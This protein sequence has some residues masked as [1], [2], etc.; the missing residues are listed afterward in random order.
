MEDMSMQYD[1]W[2]EFKKE[3]E[4][5]LGFSLLNGKWLVLKP[6]KPLPW[7]DTDLE[8]VLLAAIRLQLT[9]HKVTPARIS[10]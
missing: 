6:R 3:C 5:Q 1:T 10:T 9:G 2:Y 4:R 8:A 7:D